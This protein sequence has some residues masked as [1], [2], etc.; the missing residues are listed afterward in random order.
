MKR[1]ALRSSAFLGPRGMAGIISAALKPVA[2]TAGLSSCIPTLRE[3]MEGRPLARA[4]CQLRCT[5]PQPRMIADEDPVMTKATHS[6]WLHA[7]GADVLV[8]NHLAIFSAIASMGL[9]RV[10][11]TQGAQVAEVVDPDLD[12]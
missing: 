8:S 7:V 4:P 1:G 2:M 12:R 5:M 6:S 3:I 11:V 9:A 10:E